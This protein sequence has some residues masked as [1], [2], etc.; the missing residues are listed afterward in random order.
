MDELAQR[1]DSNATW[2]DLVLPDAPRQILKNIAALVSERL[3]VYESCGSSAQKIHEP[4]ITALFVGHSGT[5]KTVPAEALA[6][7]LHLDLYR[8]DSNQL[9]NKYIGETEKNLSEIFDKA[10]NKNWILLFDEADTLF[11]KRNEVKDAHNRYANNEINY[12][13]QR[14]EN[15]HGL[16]IL[17]T[18]KKD[19]IDNAFMSRIHFVVQFPLSSLK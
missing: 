18:D 14:M 19:L 10:E 7:E 1:I 8:I 12:L 11:D 17:T 9:V 5:G 4:G 15:Y 2:D 6:N 3:K 16:T 13:F